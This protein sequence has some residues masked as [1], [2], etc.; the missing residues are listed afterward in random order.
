M[1]A[2]ECLTLAKAAG[3]R[4]QHPINAFID[5]FRR[6]APEERQRLVA[7]PPSS[8]GTLEGLVSAVVSALCRELGDA[9]PSWVEEV[10]SPEPFFAFPA[11]SYAMRI[12][13]MLESPPA[14]LIRNVFVPANYLARA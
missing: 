2:I 3:A 6:A 12:R 13:L 8:V 11:R 5:D 7:E 4:F 9:A 1:T 14:F 10:G